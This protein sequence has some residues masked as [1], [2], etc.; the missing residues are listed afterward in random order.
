ITCAFT[1]VQNSTKLWQGNEK[2]MRESLEIHNQIM[3]RNLQLYR[4][5]EVK[6]NGDSFYVAFRD[7]YDAML[8]AM[9]VQLELLSAKWPSDLYHEWDCR[10]EW[11]SKT[12]K[13]YWSGLRVRIGL[14]YGKGDCVFDK[15]M[16]RYDYFGT[17]VNKSARIEALAHGGQ[18]CVS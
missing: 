11:D 10:Q 6:T 15:T 5:Y 8:W 16:K 17:V 14:H 13:A 2:A 4:G 1:D 18:V 3:R 12:R 7:P 9:A